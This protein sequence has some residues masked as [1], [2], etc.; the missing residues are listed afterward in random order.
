[1][2]EARNAIEYTKQKR[3]FD[4]FLVN[5]N[6]DGTV[7]LT[8]KLPHPYRWRRHCVKMGYRWRNVILYGLWPASNDNIVN[9]NYN[10]SLD[11]FIC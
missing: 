6:D 11:S 7:T 8:L 10:F 2:A 9:C 1:M 4:L 3:N 5:E